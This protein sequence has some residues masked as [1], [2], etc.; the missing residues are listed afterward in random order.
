MKINVVG[1]ALENRLFTVACKYKASLMKLK[2]RTTENYD[3]G[4]I[5]TAGVTRNPTN[6]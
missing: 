6:K 5:R 1:P 2:E 3:I 4:R